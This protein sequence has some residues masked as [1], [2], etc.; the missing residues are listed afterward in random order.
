[1]SA[2]SAAKKTSAAK[3]AT[4]AKTAS[5]PPPK[6]AAEPAS[7]GPTATEQKTPAPEAPEAPRSAPSGISIEE[8]RKILEDVRAGR[9]KELGPCRAALPL[10]FT[11]HRQP[12][13]VDELST[14]ERRQLVAAGAD[15]MGEARTPEAWLEQDEESFSDALEVWDV[16]DAKGVPVYSL[17]MYLTDNG[18]VFRVGSTEVV[19]GVSQGGMECAEEGLEEALLDAKKRVSKDLLQRSLLRFID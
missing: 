3:R 2:P 17:W 19:G 15:G 18:T 13:S 11:K 6:P 9:K 16:V 1:V 8:A 12:S 14:I 7:A 4:P 5:A 10:S